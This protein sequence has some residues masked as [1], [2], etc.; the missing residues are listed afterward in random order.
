[1][2]PYSFKPIFPK[3]EKKMHKLFEFGEQIKMLSHSDFM[4]QVLLIFGA[5]ILL[6]MTL[7]VASLVSY[8]Y[9]NH[10]NEGAGV[11]VVS[12]FGIFTSILFLVPGLMILA[13]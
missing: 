7:V 8:Q 2:K 4:G 11:A 12:F 1:M 13:K 3:K 6:E 9:R 5:F 10:T